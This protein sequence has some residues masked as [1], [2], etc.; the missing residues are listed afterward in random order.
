M[1]LIGY[2]TLMLASVCAVQASDLKVI[3]WNI[4]DATPHSKAWFV[5]KVAK[6]QKADILALQNVNVTPYY[7]A[8]DLSEALGEKWAYKLSTAAKG[9]KQLAIFW[10]TE[11]VRLKTSKVPNGGIYEEQEI[12]AGDVSNMP[13]QVAYFQKGAFDF[14]LINVDLMTAW[15]N[16]DV[17]VK[18]AEVLESWVS[19]NKK[20]L[21][22]TENDFIVVGGLDF[23]AP[24]EK[25]GDTNKSH[26]SYT[27]LEGK[28]LLS[29][30]THTEASHNKDASFSYVSD[31]FDDYRLLDGFALSKG[32][33]RHYVKGSS[34][35]LRVDKKFADMDEYESKVSGHLPVIAR[36]KTNFAD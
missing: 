1:K 13:A 3:S 20:Q 19:G 26:P 34:V 18:Q 10:N 32:A 21:S 15:E 22:G 35:P 31:W 24:G 33:K 5:A 36:F 16:N 25:I 23:A 6:E 27:I 29:F 9:N 14:F 28:G 4:E 30:V 17:K 7:L 12:Q 11:T 2:I 8:N